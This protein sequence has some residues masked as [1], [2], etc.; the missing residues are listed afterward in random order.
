MVSFSKIILCSCFF[1]ILGCKT[2]K[3]YQIAWTIEENKLCSFKDIKGKKKVC[4]E[5]KEFDSS[6]WILLNREVLREKFN[7]ILDEFNTNLSR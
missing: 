1:I 2:I 6:Q 5:P 4:K 7:K 3:P